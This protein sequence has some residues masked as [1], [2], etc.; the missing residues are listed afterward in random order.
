MLLEEARHGLSLMRQKWRKKKEKVRRHKAHR[1]KGMGA[2]ARGNEAMN[3]GGVRGEVGS[4]D[5]RL[6]SHT[7][8]F[9]FFLESYGKS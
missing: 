8:K 3:S 6:V 9:A 1:Y 7:K 2:S 5:G 4:I